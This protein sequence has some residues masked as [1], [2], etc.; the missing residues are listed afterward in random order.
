VPDAAVV[1]DAEGTIV[2][3]NEHT[4]TQFGYELG[5]LVGQPVEI[6]IP[7]RFRHRHRGY[8]AEYSA[9]PRARA[10]GAGLRLFGRRRDGAEFPVDI[11]LAPVT[12]AD[13]PLVVA[14][15]RDISDRVAATAAQ[16]RLAAIVQS[17]QDA[18]VSMSV[19]GAVSSWNPGATQL[20]GYNGEDI[21]DRHVSQL[22]PRDESGGPGSRAV[23]RAAGCGGSP[24]CPSPQGYKVT[25]IAAVRAR[26]DRIPY[27][28]GESC[29]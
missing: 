18:I 27:R 25:R 13:E 8:R 22:I 14:A 26:V 19:E 3:A 1:V 24:V 6:L 7:E 28:P 16:A 4:A 10:M 17:S 11:S 20:F 5:D 15:V 12:N 21:L 29:D 23:G 2:S 9:A